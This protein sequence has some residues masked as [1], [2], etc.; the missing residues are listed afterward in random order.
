MRSGRTANFICVCGLLPAIVI[1]ARVDCATAQP[2]LGTE[3][4]VQSSGVD[5]DVPGYSVPSFVLWDGDDLKDLIVGEGSGS[6]TARVRIYLNEGT[7]S[8]PQFSG[9]SY[10]QSNGIPLVLAGG[11]CLGLFPR[12]VHW[13]GDGRKD[14]LVGMADGKVKIFL[15]VGTDDDPTF[16]RGTFLQVGEPGSKIDIDVGARATCSTVDWNN[17]DRKDLL[18]GALDSKIHIFL[19]EGTDSAPDFRSETFA[20]AGGQ[21][22]LVPAGRSSPVI[23]DL[24]GDGQKDLLVGNTNGQLLFYSN[25][26]TDDA[27]SFSGYVQMEVG[28]IVIDHAGSARSRPFVADWTDDGLPDVLYGAD[29]GRVH[30]LQNVA[31]PG[32]IDGDGNLD[33]DDVEAFAAVL[34]DIPMDPHH[35][36]RADLNGDDSADGL[37]TRPFVDLLVNG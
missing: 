27:P 29:C 16:D 24:D 32:D 37:D 12:T 6:A 34:L 1:L 21:D 14:L 7:A 5:I 2:N 28:G 17:D 33:T 35:V 36:D 18:T 20:Q 22:L 11:G 26:G 30:L 23:L 4:F 10:A 25:T 8:E 15:N 9:Y 31:I 3:Q 19:N 13:D